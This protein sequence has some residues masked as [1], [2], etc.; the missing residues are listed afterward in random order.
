MAQ[1]PPVSPAAQTCNPPNPAWFEYWR[2]CRAT[3]G[4]FEGLNERHFTAGLSIITTVGAIGV[5]VVVAHLVPSH[6]AIEAVGVALGLTLPV[7]VIL[8]YY[9]LGLN[10][11]LMVGAIRA[12]IEAEHKL[13]PCGCQRPA[14]EACNP[15]IMECQPAGA[16]CSI[17]LSCAIE[18]QVPVVTQERRRTQL[19]V[20]LAVIAALV[21]AA[22]IY[23]SIWS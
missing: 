13:L 18:A 9:L 19:F 16:S 5:A 1:S 10:F 17:H 8:L 14:G 22:L 11:Q 6:A 4:K 3:I 7:G 20:V 15:K 21:G 12:S 23:V 2:E